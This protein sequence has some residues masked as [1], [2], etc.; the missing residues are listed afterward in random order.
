VAWVSHLALQPTSN[1]FASVGVMARPKL[2]LLPSEM[3]NNSR[4]RELH[5][6]N[7]V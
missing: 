7:T 2:P 5:S 4:G 3:Q 6:S 1:D